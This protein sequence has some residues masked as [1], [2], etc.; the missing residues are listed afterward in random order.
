MAE[1]MQVKQSTA[2]DKNCDCNVVQVFV[3][4]M[5]FPN[6]MTLRQVEAMRC[7][8]NYEGKIAAQMAEE[9]KEQKKEQ[10]EA[11]KMLDGMRKNTKKGGGKGFKNESNTHKNYYHTDKAAKVQHKKAK[12]VKK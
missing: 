9:E 6:K 7:I 12:K 4:K 8:A 2:D 1:L 3:P 11:K 10:D 5:K